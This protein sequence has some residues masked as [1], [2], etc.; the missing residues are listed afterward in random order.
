MGTGARGLR[1]VLENVLS[2]SMFE[3]PGSSVKYVLVTEDVI[4]RKS[5]PIHLGR[6]QRQLF[7]NLLS[8]EEE[9]ERDGDRQDAE[10]GN[11]QEY[12]EKV[13]ASAV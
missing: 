11:F 5:A 12:R 7:E 3:V 4:L 10:V 8:Q 1:G 6:G 13:S 9:R 2:E